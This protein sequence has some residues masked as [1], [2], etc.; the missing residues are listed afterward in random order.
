MITLHWGNLEALC[1]DC[2]KKEHHEDVESTREGF[3]FDEE[4]N[5]VRSDE[6]ATC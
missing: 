4:G 6:A 5:L 3:A 1:D 2:H